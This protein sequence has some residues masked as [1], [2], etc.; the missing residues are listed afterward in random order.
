VGITQLQNYDY[1]SRY[2]NDYITGKKG[3]YNNEKERAA[4]IL[5]QRAEKVI[6]ELSKH[7]EVMEIDTPLT[8]K[9]YTCNYNGAAIGWANTVNQ[10]SPIN[11][12]SPTTPI[13]DLYSSSALTFPR[14][15]QI[16]VIVCG[17]R[18]RRKLIGR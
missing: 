1:W 11:R 6:P 18:L 12:M 16:G 15:S 3:G 14:G 13:K 17:Y 8:F 9:R 5:I 2:E 7:I 4:K 10:C